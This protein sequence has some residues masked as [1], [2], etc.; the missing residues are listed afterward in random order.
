MGILAT[1]GISILLGLIEYFKVLPIP[2]SLPY[3]LLKFVIYG[4]L[5]AGVSR[6]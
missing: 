2:D 4:L 1:L 3:M 6:L 5:I